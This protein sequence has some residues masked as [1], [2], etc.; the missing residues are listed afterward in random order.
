MADGDLLFRIREEGIICLGEHY[1][2]SRH[3]LAGN[4]T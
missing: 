2:P 1:Q 4:M 3:I